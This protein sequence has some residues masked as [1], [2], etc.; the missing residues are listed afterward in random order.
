MLA[1]LGF[2]RDLASRLDCG[3]TDD[4]HATHVAYI[5]DMNVKYGGAFLIWSRRS[6]HHGYFRAVVIDDLASACGFDG[7]VLVQ[8]QS[9][10]LSSRTKRRDAYTCCGWLSDR[11]SLVDELEAIRS[12]G[13]F[14]SDTDVVYQLDPDEPL[15]FDGWIA[16]RIDPA[17]LEARIAEL[18]EAAL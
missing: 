10:F 17:T 14:D 15:T 5:G 2:G 7:A 11:T 6:L 9:C 16:E 13:F 4:P 8:E 3:P 1:T 12:Y 18:V